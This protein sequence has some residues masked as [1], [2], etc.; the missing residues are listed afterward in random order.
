MSLFGKSL[1]DY[2]VFTRYGIVLIL[3]MGVTRFLV[4]IS[5]VPYEKATNLV[6][7]T[8]LTSLLSF[9]YG[10]KAA[11]TG[12]GRYRQLLPTAGMLS[13]SMYGFIVLAILVEGLSGIHGYFHGQTLE[14]AAAQFDRLSPGSG[15]AAAGM[16]MAT[17]IE[18]QL[19]V[20]L[21]ATVFLWG[22]ASLGFL[23]SRYLGYLRNAFLLLAGMAVL[24]ILAGAAGV[25]YAI[26]TWVTSL[27]LL[28][29]ALPVYYGFRA[30]SNGFSRYGQM[31]PIGALIA[32]GMNLLVMYGIVVTTG[33]DIPNY[34]QV[35]GEG[36]QAP[37]ISTAQHVTGHL[38]FSL[39]AAVVTSILACAGLFLSKRR[40]STPAS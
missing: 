37:D 7:V 6:S 35:P 1:R 8:I 22:L 9:V 36:L 10:C 26:G 39:P 19:I 14:A 5:G 17:H 38:L 4:G 33:L 27:T 23:C 34:F 29:M 3:S 15:V 16:S 25:P 18:G 13:A 32:I 30:P 12:F 28:A 40:A 2:G 21:P 31:F 20:M 24:R 11:E